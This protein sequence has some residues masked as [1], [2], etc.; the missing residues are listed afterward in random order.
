MRE[1]RQNIGLGL[2]FLGLVSLALWRVVIAL[3]LNPGINVFSLLT[4]LL[5]SALGL[6][7]LDYRRRSR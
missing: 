2:F 3:H 6:A 5:L 1:M 7:I 4:G